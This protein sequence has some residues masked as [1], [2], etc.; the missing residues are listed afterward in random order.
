MLALM[1]TPAGRPST[2]DPFGPTSHA[3]DTVGPMPRAGRAPESL[4]ENPTLDDL[5]THAVRLPPEA[6][7]ERLVRAF[8]D[9]A[10]LPAVV[11]GDEHQT[12]G[13]VSRHAFFRE[14]SRKYSSELY[15]R[16]PISLLLDLMG[17]PSLSLDHSMGFAEAASLALQ[18]AGERAF[19]PIL[20]EFPDR[21]AEA[22]DVHQLMLGQARLLERACRREEQRRQASK[23]EA[24]GQLAG[25]IA[26]DFNNLL[27]VILGSLDL[28]RLRLGDGD[29]ARDRLVTDA[30]RAA[31]RAA[32]LTSRLLGFARQKPSVTR[33]VDLSELVYETES[34]LRTII[35]P[36]IVMDAS[37]EPGLWRIEADPTQM[38]QVLMNLCVNARDAMPD[39][40]RLT[41]KTENCALTGGDLSASPEGES[42]DFVRLCVEDTG[43]GIEPAILPRIFEPFFT[44]KGPGGGT[45]LGLAMIYTIVK[46]ANGWIECRSR[47]G[48]GTVFTLYLPRAREHDLGGSDGS[49]VPER[50]RE[51][52]LGAQ[53]AAACRVLVVDDEP[54]IRNVAE[55]M[56]QRAGHEVILAED[57]AAAIDTYRREGARIDLVLLDLT[58]PRISGIE[59]FRRLR[60]LDPNVSVL[61]CSGYSSQELSRAERDGALGFV[62][63]P[64]RMDELT[65]AVAKA[66]DERAA[67]RGA[68]KGSTGD[69]SS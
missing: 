15:S 2:I 43:V 47:V 69:R 26:H 56:L 39:G 54:I 62:N 7:G 30:E 50:P 59:A 12:I 3:P 57:G 14:M 38:G 42:G 53:R 44:T 20:V 51:P 21:L 52:A 18:R 33:S 22:L 40:G 10:E 65:G 45:G 17:G 19:E 9:D 31:R 46:Q 36:R 24:I 5:V 55:A 29:I 49:G 67:R 23:M 25:G 35:D 13:L 60:E 48:H 66:L 63:K 27:T 16:R 32:D 41:L 6:L 11:I 68:L 1:T 8:A 4:P 58:M 61:F 34:L 28:L 37:S 64:Y